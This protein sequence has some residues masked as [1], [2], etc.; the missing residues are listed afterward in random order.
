[1]AAVQR[2][3]LLPDRLAIVRYEPS[4]P[5]D[6]EFDAAGNGFFSFIRTGNEV[7][8][9]MDQKR[10]P[11][12]APKKSTGWRLFEVEGPFPFD[13]VGILA[14]VTAPLAVAGVSIFALATFDTDYFLVQGRQL[15]RAV[16]ALRKAGHTVSGPGI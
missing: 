5:L 13:A 6:L 1:M 10:V 11:R 2:I 7:S 15:R 14:S 12:K 9:V 3:R 8:L 4:D 16:T